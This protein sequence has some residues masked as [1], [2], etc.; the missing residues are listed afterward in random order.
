M[1]GQQ[2]S[3][4]VILRSTN[5][6]V[7]WTSKTFSGTRLTDVATYTSGSFTYFV[8]VSSNAN[9]YYSMNGGSTWSSNIVV[10]YALQGVTIGS[11][12]VA[13]AVGATSGIL[14][15]SRSSNYST[16]SDVSSLTLAS[17]QLY[18]VCSADGVNVVA[19]GASGT[20]YTSSDSGTTWSSSSS[21]VTTTLYAVSCASTSSTVVAAGASAAMLLSNDQGASWSA[22]NVVGVGSV[23][24][25][26]TFQFHCVTVLNSYLF[27][28][29]TGVGTIIVSKNGGHSWALEKSVSSSPIYGLSMYSSSLGVGSNGQGFAI[30]KSPAPT[31][32]PTGQPTRQ[33]S[34]Q[35]SAQ[36]SRQPYYTPTSQP[37]STA[38]ATPHYSAH[39]STDPTAHHPAD[40]AAILAPK[41]SAQLPAEYAAYGPAQQSTHGPTVHAALVPAHRAAD[42]P[43]HRTALAAA[44]LAS[45]QTA[46]ESAY[47]AALGAAHNSTLHAAILSTYESAYRTAYHAT[48]EAA[49]CAAHSP[50]DAATDVSAEQTALRTALDTAVLETHRG[51]HH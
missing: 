27:Y 32:A 41:L 7:S 3:A 38:R 26:T 43:T 6:G 21:G 5:M 37:P 19:V 15:S 20:V 36:P 16:W 51:P 1:A 39:D 30:L 17:V 50:A 18:A 13:Y 31:R 35:P 42:E 23:T 9:I 34:R 14:T 48:H 33:P 40:G 12:G 44:H 45:L 24:A 2:L 28:A 10:S 25:S 8:I 47:H 49:D 11:N 29:S 4:G 46:D 22:M